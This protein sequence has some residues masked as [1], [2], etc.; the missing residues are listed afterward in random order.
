MPLLLLS[1]RS[2]YSAFPGS[3]AATVLDVILVLQITGTPWSLRFAIW[4]SI[5]LTEILP[6]VDQWPSN[7]LPTPDTEVTWAAPGVA[8]AWVWSLFLYF[9]MIISFS[10]L[11]IYNRR[12][13]LVSTDEP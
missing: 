3:L 6:E 9:C 1:L 7:F 5:L 4:S 2:L 11:G 13:N 12:K 10:Y 8:P